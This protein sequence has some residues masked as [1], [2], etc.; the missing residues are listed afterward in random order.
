[1]AM[2]Q[3]LLR[4]DLASPVPA[5]RQIAAGLRTLLVH[6]DLPAG[7]RLPTIRELAMDLGVHPNTVAQAYRVLSDEGWLELRRRRGA[8]VRQRPVPPAG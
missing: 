2:T 4:I 7:S 6:G 1:M 5:Y 8:T 3:P